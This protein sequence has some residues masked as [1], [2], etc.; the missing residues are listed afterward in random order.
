[1]RVPGFARFL[2]DASWGLDNLA[3]QAKSASVNKPLV[4]A[5]ALFLLLPGCR[6]EEPQ[7][8]VRPVVARPPV[9]AKPVASATAATDPNAEPKAES[10]MVGPSTGDGS[11]ALFGTKKIEP[12]DITI[13][14]RDYIASRQISPSTIKSL[15]VLVEKKFL[16]NLPPPPPGKKYVWDKYLVVSLADK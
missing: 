12:A 8:V 1:M 4:A 10:T 16:P 3:A 13:A 15:D 6:K 2:A 7:P 5:I 11:A 9:A 14:L